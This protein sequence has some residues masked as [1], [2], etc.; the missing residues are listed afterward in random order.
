MHT[1]TEA[2]MCLVYKTVSSEWPSGLAHKIVSELFKKY[3]SQDTMTKVELRQQ[4]SRVTLKKNKDLAK[5]FE[6]LAAIK[7][8]YNTSEKQIDEE[9]LIATILEKAP[10]KYQ[11]LLTAEQLQL[12][13]SVTVEHL[14]LAMTTH[15]QSIG[16]GKR[17]SRPSTDGEISLSAFGG[18]CFKCKEKGHKAHQCPKKY[19][20]NKGKK[21]DGK[22]NHCGKEGHKYAD[23][24][25]H[26]E[27]SSKRPK[28]FKPSTQE[29]SNIAVD[30]GSKIELCL[31][32]LTFPDDINILLDPNVWIA[33]SGNTVDN[34]AHKEGLEVI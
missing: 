20:N 29:H 34:T 14:R 7:N 2:T 16:K 6:Q 10:N 9:E 4:L 18:V 30:S 17:N 12:R 19:N 33:D 21:L 3:Q 27:S 23:C 25:Q 1:A 31:C 13:E 22:C 24:W 32:G 28:N 15:W 11:S 5:L 8:R 26:E